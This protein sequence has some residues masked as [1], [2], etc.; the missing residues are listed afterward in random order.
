MRAGSEPCLHLRVAA[1]CYEGVRPLAGPAQRVLSQAG[2]APALHTRG[3]RRWW[4]RCRRLCWRWRSWR[5]CWRRCWCC[6]VLY[7]WERD[8]LAGQERAG[9]ERRR[10][11]RESSQ[12]GPGRVQLQLQV[13]GGGLHQDSLQDVRVDC[14]QQDGVSQDCLQQGGVDTGGG[15]LVI[16]LVN[17]V[18]GPVGGRGELGVPHTQGQGQAAACK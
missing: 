4:R 16:V 3:G 10:S 8:L 2:P 18:L 14:L 6:C 7:L 17:P 5:R 12:A 9:V 1:G 13:G 11:C 15:E